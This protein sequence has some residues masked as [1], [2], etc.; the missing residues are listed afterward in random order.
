M[1]QAV[2]DSRYRR[3]TLC[4]NQPVLESRRAAVLGH[5]I[6]HSL[7]PTLHR[8]AYQALGLPWHYEAVDIESGG[9][10]QFVAGLGPDWAGL[11][12]TMP[13]KVEAVPLMDFI[14]PLAKI[15][16]AVN[17]VLFQR[18]ADQR[19]LVGANTDVHGIVAA[20]REGGIERASTAVIIGGGATATAALAA[21]GQLGVVTP[22]VAVRDRA[23]AGA[24]LRASTKMGVTVRFANLDD[25]AELAAGAD[26]VVSTIPA[27]AGAGIGD[28]VTRAS[29]VL[30][31]VIYS[32]LLTPLAAAWVAAG[33][34]RVGGE[35][36]LL[37]QAGEQVR[38]MTGSPAP[39]KDMDAALRAVLNC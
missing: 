19:H 10:A 9:L 8:A 30:L 17:T 14:E 24:L 15:V 11:S 13:L 28:T 23:R 4:L 37:H 33:G 31:D 21:V 27:D 7:S 36:M 34:T 16:G 32:P 38:L 39:I 25:A 5:P 3:F 29:G 1:S 6:A 2:V 22:I 35:R 12:L 20:L 26:V 18:F